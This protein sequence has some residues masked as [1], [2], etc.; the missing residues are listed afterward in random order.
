[1]APG[2]GVIISL[3]LSIYCKQVISKYKK[4]WSYQITTDKHLYSYVGSRSSVMAPGGGV[5]ISLKLSI[6]SNQVMNK[7]IKGWGY[8]ITK[9][10]HL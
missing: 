3:K 8:Q 7:C 4:G 2:G 1:M 9:I 6:D 10:K 5:I